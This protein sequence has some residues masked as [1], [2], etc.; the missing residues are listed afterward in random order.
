M[1]EFKVFMNYLRFVKSRGIYKLKFITLG[2]SL[3]NVWENYIKKIKY[4]KLK[5]EKNFEK[6]M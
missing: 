1:L 6:D 4:G 2:Y 3:L 5:G